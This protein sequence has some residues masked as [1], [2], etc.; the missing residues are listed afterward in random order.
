MKSHNHLKHFVLQQKLTFSTSVFDLPHYAV[1][2]PIETP[3]P[4]NITD[5]R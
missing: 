1:L 4:V 2:S 5:D 3:L